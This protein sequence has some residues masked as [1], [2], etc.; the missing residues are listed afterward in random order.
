MFMQTWREGISQ[1]AH[2]RGKKF[3]VH[4]RSISST[5]E[6]ST[7]IFSSYI[8]LLTGAVN[9]ILMFIWELCSI[10]ERI[11]EDTRFAPG[12]TRDSLREMHRGMHWN[13][14]GGFSSHAS[15]EMR[16]D[17]RI[18]LLCTCVI[19]KRMHLARGASDRRLLSF[20]FNRSQER[21]SQ[22]CAT[23]MSRMSSIAGVFRLPYTANDRYP[24]A[25]IMD[26]SVAERLGCSG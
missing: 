4:S 17:V 16:F 8:F 19:A 11:L 1:A 15:G 25:R 5:R 9:W 6:W 21:R 18:Y 23:S 7:E 26:V 20:G 22:F 10:L 24:D 12:A 13:A 3:Y 2:P 14:S